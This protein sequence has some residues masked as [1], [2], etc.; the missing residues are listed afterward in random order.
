MMCDDITDN[1]V[2][3]YSYVT[4]PQG[5]RFELYLS[6]KRHTKEDVIIAKAQLKQEQDVVQFYTFWKED[7]EWLELR[8][9]LHP[10][11][12]QNN[13]LNTELK[14]YILKHNLC[15]SLLDC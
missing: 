15:S 2:K 14:E 5:A 13:Q 4:G 8:V 1:L 7:P 3:Y 6:K 9:F 12:Q 11:A 10:N